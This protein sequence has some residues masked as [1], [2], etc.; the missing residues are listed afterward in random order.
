MRH[1]VAVDP[2]GNVY[3][4]ANESGN[5]FRIA[6]GGEVEEIHGI[7]RGSVLGAPAGVA[8]ARDGTAFAI[9]MGMGAL[10]R[11]SPRSRFCW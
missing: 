6:A 4:S 3:V 2:S 10:W 9:R 5:V 11:F 1:G 8:V 7:P